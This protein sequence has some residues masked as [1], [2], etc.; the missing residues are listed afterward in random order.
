VVCG[1]LQELIPVIATE[2]KSSRFSTSN[3][4]HTVIS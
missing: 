2:S 4:A 1:L 3:C